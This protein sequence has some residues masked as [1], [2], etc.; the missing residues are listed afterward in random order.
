MKL[1]DLIKSIE[2]VNKEASLACKENLDNVAK[3]VGSLGRLED[4][5]VKIAG[6]TG[7][8]EIDVSKKALTVYCADNGV[9]KHGVAL[10]GHPVTTAVVQIL[11]MGK[12]SVSVMAESCNT[13]VFVTDI[14]MVDQVEGI[15][16]KKLMKGTDDM[17]I[18][19]AMTR[20][21]AEKAILI[22]IKKVKELKDKGYRVIATGETGMGNT[23]SSAAI[24]SVLLG[25]SVKDVTGPGA[26][27]DSRGLLRKISVIEKAIEVNKPNVLDPIDVL[28][29]VGGLDIAAMA[30]V[31]LGG[32][33]YKVPVVM[34]GFISG[35][36]AL[37]AVK[38]N[39]NVR[40]YII[41]SHKSD[42]PGASYLVEE[43]GVIPIIQASMRLGEGT[44]AVALLPL[45]D[46][47]AAV[48]N[49]AATYADIMVNKEGSDL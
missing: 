41:P 40:D 14:G 30:G 42:E 11:S 2:P 9:V 34:D 5:I 35:T 31:F 21:S 8:K 7:S 17:T 22:G 3:P 28:H 16:N 48:Y 44:G 29:K 19:P 39:P 18:G 32:A 43:L 15:E 38:L 6:I 25:K 24:C 27:V 1:E 26:G 4:F 46:M 49:K 10:H 20:E 47:A 12:S 33:I 36:A 13:D 23:T 45:L 37:L